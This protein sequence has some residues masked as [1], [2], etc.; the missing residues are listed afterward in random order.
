MNKEKQGKTWFKNLDLKFAGAGLVLLFV[1]MVVQVFCRCIF[2]KPIIWADAFSSFMLSYLTFIGSIYTYRKRDNL[3]GF[4]ALRNML[5][6]VPKLILLIFMRLIAVGCFGVIAASFFAVIK[7]N[8]N[9]VNTYLWNMPYWIYFGP[10]LV[11]FSAMTVYS[12]IF[13]V[14]DIKALFNRELSTDEITE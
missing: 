8:P 10:G 1:V 2:N 13:L 9:S 11:G 4:Y 14:R 7:I 3:I 12:V 6:R 5:P